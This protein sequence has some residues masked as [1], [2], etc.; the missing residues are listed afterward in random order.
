MTHLIIWWLSLSGGAK[1]QS[2]EISL[3]PSSALWSNLEI[4]Y[5]VLYTAAFHITSGTY[6]EYTRPP[7]GLSNLLFYNLQMFANSRRYSLQN[8]YLAHK[9]SCYFLRGQSW[10]TWLCT[11]A[12][13]QVNVHQLHSKERINVKSAT[14]QTHH[15]STGKDAFWCSAGTKSSSFPALKSHVSFLA[16]P[17]SKSSPKSHS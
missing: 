13:S 7:H 8:L 11:L 17:V 6:Y 14:F 15:L 2:L 12:P 16:H 5:F 4:V 1:N 3:V 9:A 10:L